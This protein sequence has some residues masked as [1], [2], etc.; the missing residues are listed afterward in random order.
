MYLFPVF[1]K[2]IKSCLNVGV[3]VHLHIKSIEQEHSVKGHIYRLWQEQ[4]HSIPT[5]SKSLQVNTDFDGVG[6]RM[7]LLLL[8]AFY[9]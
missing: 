1:V 3:T 7:F 6:D 2:R 9:V 5:P 8:D 4:E